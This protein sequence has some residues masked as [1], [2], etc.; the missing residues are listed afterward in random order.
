MACVTFDPGVRRGDDLAAEGRWHEALREYEAAAERSPGDRRVQ[1]RLEHAR[2]EVAADLVEAV[3]RALEVRR[4]DRAED[5]ARDAFELQPDARAVR[6]A[7]AR[8]ASALAEEANALMEEDEDAERAW[9]AIERAAELDADAP[10]VRTV[11]NRLRDAYLAHLRAQADELEAAGRAAP[12]LVALVRISQL[13]RAEPDLAE[14]ISALRSW[15]HGQAGF[16][17]EMRRLGAIPRLRG[18]AANLTER[19]SNLLPPDGCPN[20]FVAPRAQEG[21][22]ISVTGR[23]STFGFENHESRRTEVHT[24]QSGTRTV[25][26]PEWPRKKA[27]FEQA[28]AD[29][30]AAIEEVQ[31]LMREV[32]R[33][34][35]EVVESGPGD[36][37][38][39]RRRSLEE[40]RRSLEAARADAQARNQ[41]LA[42]AHE[43]FQETPETLEE[44]VM[45]DGD[46]V[47]TEVERVFEAAVTV[48]ARDI[49]TGDTIWS[50]RVFEA[51]TETEASHHRGLRPAGIEPVPL[52]F[53]K[54]DETLREEAL[55]SIESAVREGIGEVCRA[56]RETLRQNGL[57]LAT[58]NDVAGATEWLVQGLFFD[59]FGEL[60]DWDVD[61]RVGRFFREAWSL[62]DPGQIIG[63]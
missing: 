50:D 36:D 42:A 12:A 2:T 25:P 31:D 43:A 60:E 34:E 30:D 41:E 59:P 1:E 52:A 4:F 26:N 16:A 35:V 38:A 14:R 33:R 56:H 63:P 3:N 18:H 51:S 6:D 46:L 29:L 54:D 15:M 28:Q 24:Y 13:S 49:T 44:P 19:F 21:P 58:S 57:R 23:L 39:A 37:V 47:V 61:G 55:S 45:T 62:E 11:R 27:D 20:L 53:P 32:S 5:L 8:V 9:L 48:S 10:G 40:A 17:V 7:R 22:G